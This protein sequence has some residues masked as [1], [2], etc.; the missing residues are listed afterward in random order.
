MKWFKP[1]GESNTLNPQSLKY[2]ADKWF[3]VRESKVRESTLKRN[4]N[5]MG[6]FFSIVNPKIN[7]KDFNLEV[8]ESF[9]KKRRFQVTVNTLNID[10]RC[11]N[12][13]S[14][15]LL[16]HEYIEKK[17]KIKQHKAPKLPEKYI[18]E[19]N[20]IKLINEES[21]PSWVRDACKVYW[22]YGFRKNELIQGRLAPN[23]VLIIPAELS[24]TNTEYSIRLEPWAVKIIREVHRRRDED[25]AKGHRDENFGERL[26]ELVIDGYKK[27]GFYEVNRTNLHSL[28]HSFGCR[29]YL[30]SGDIAQVQVAM[31]H[32]DDKSTKGYVNLNKEELLRDF[33][34]S[35]KNSRFLDNMERIEQDNKDS[36]SYLD[37]A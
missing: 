24:K 13:F 34:T 4:N 15:W 35:A 25:R 21:I 37:V 14:T 26:S 20:F 3:N 30:V 23:N 27:I 33:P 11:I 6:A 28:R 22:S 1:K 9:E 29:M 2:Y 32:E 12:T 36:L 17:I 10:L 19:Q 18:C 31:R 5:S 7:I 16:D 8:I